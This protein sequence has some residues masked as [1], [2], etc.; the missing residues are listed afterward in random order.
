MNDSIVIPVV[1][2]LFGV[3]GSLWVLG[4]VLELLR[5]RRLRKDIREGTIPVDSDQISEAVQEMNAEDSFDKDLPPPHLRHNLS[6]LKRIR[7]D[8]ATI[9]L[10]GYSRGV[11]D[12]GLKISFD[13]GVRANPH[14]PGT[15]AAKQWVRGYCMGTNVINPKPYMDKA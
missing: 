12:Y 6:N 15:G 2:F 14:P 3:W 13:V 11:I 10:D 7:S 5:K 1:T 8:V 4:V 9:R